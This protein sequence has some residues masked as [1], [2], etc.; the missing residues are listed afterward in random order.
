[1]SRFERRA[2]ALTLSNRFCRAPR[3]VYLPFVIAFEANVIVHFGQLRQFQQEIHLV[4]PCCLAAWLE[5][6]GH[7]DHLQT[8]RRTFLRLLKLR[9][10]RW[11]DVLDLCSLTF[12]SSQFAGGQLGNLKRAVPVFACKYDESSSALVVGNAGVNSSPVN[13]IAK[14]FFVL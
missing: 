10:I 8:T 2:A 7:V 14:K 9:H 11:L 4:R 1:M 6:Y 12:D 3:R 13:P 5:G